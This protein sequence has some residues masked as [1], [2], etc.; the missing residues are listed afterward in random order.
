MPGSDAPVSAVNAGD[1][2]VLVECGN[3]RML[4][5]VTPTTTCVDLIKSASTTMSEKIDVKSAVLL[6]HFGTVGIQRPLRR[7]E[8][9]RNVMN[10]WD[11][12]RQNSL[13]LI[14]PRTGSSESELSM[15][16]AP[17]K[18]PEEAFWLLTYSQRPGKW[19][20]RYIT[21]KSDGQI[22]C[23]KD[24]DKPRDQFNVCHLSDF[25]ISLHR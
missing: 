7:Y 3:S 12:D 4:F 2:R 8:S 13:I 21:L 15:D 22:T 11:S 10:S 18:R 19:E 6:E 25:D 17:K 1:R 16:G 20:K 5:P 23:Q 14:D 24:L 9:V